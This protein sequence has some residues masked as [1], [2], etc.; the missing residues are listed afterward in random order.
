MNKIF[1]PNVYI[2]SVHPCCLKVFRMH[3][4]CTFEYLE[5]SVSHASLE[6]YDKAL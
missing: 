3:F 5:N 1:F 2:G 6:R 4:S